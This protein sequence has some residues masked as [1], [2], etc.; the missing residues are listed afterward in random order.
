AT[1]PPFPIRHP[2]PA[3]RRWRRKQA[4]EGC[5]LSAALDQE[6]SSSRLTALAVRARRLM[7]RVELRRRSQPARQARTPGLAPSLLRLPNGPADLLPS[8]NPWRRL[9]AAGA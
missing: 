5:R 2:A 1:A 6:R 3:C 9:A 4:E 7:C 8:P